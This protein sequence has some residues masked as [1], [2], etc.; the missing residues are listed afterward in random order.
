MIRTLTLLIFMSI[1]SVYLPACEDASSDSTKVQTSG[2]S[3][4]G[5]Q[6]GEQEDEPRGGIRAPMMDV[7]IVSAGE[8]TIDMVTAEE[9]TT[10]MLIGSEMSPI[11]AMPP[12]QDA[13]L[14]LQ[15]LPTGISMHSVEQ[16]I[17]GIQT[18]RRYLIHAPDTLEANRMYPIVLALHGSG[19][20]G[21]SFRPRLRRYVEDQRFIGVYPDGHNN[22]WNL[23][24]Q[25]SNAD[26]VSFLSDV[27]SEVSTY[28]HLDTER[29]FILGF[30]NGAGMAHQMA[31]ETHSIKGIATVVTQLSR[32]NEPTAQ[33]QPVAVLQ[34]LGMQ[35]PLI[36]YQGGMGPQN[37]DFYPG[38]RSAELWAEH[39]Q[40]T[41]PGE[42]NDNDE[43]IKITYIGCL[44]DVKVIHY[45]FK[46]ANHTPPQRVDGMSLIE[47]AIRFFEETP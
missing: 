40:C 19:G 24:G 20:R 26:D 38:E 2:M 15:P 5:A 31:I 45:G 11:D 41:L 17:D 9:I 36:P 47:V 1:Y 44:D 18:Q 14:P 22:V 16:L 28:A 3:I 46:D 21:E 6:V 8:M 23:G 13:E 39:N 34:I 29:V 37:L 35:D 10:D 43:R 25:E 30:S 7:E 27:L 12:S 33:T 4:G 32:G 42:L